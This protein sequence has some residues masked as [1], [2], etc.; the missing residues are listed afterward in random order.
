MKLDGEATAPAQRSNSGVKVLKVARLVVLGHGQCGGVRAMAVGP[1]PAA[2]L[3]RHL[4][5]YRQ[6]GCLAE[7]GAAAGGKLDKLEVEVVRLSMENLRTFPWIAAAVDS[8]RLALQGYLF[9]VHTGVLTA[10]GP[11]SAT[12]ID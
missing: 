12:P 10:I 5:R 4:G 6:A 3:R 9:D 2:R 8:G 7:A 11:D 1:P